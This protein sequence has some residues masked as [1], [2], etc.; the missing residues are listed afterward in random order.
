MATVFTTPT[1]VEYQ[2]QKDEGTGLLKFNPV[3]GGAIPTTLDG[4]YTG[5]KYA[6]VAWNTYLKTFESKPDMRLKD[7][8]LKLESKEN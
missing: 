4:W 7:N 6:D 3:A 1:K 5:Q 8:K 2:I